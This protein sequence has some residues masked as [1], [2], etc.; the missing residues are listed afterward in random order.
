MRSTTSAVTGKNLLAGLLALGLLV[1]APSVAFAQDVAQRCTRHT[2]RCGGIEREYWMYLPDGLPQGAPL[3]VALHGYGGSALKGKNGLMDKA[4]A[5]GFAVCYPQGSTDSRG[6]AFWN[7]GYPFNKTDKVDDVKFLRRLVKTLWRDFGLSRENTFMT[8]MSNGGEMCWL[9]AQKSPDTFTA[10]ASVAGLTIEGMDRVF[11]KP[12]PFMEIHGT[13]DRTSEWCGDPEDK[14][15]WGAYLA[16][17]VSVGYIAA[18]DR[19]RYEQVDTLPVRRN[20]V[21][22]YRLTGGAPAWQGGP[23]CEVRLYKVDGGRHT[24]AE[25]DM[26]T[27]GEI[28]G[29]FSQYLR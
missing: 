7:V 14:G 25:A 9:M 8:G 23:E 15:G 21:T 3:V 22:R 16:V 20:V 13:A 28:W 2:I 29:F 6:K 26:D 19:C 18:A 27:F 12:V 1:L 5:E 24:W 4:D 11:P 10:Y 17:P